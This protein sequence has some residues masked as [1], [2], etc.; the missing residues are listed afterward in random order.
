VKLVVFVFLAG[1]IAG[2]ALGRFDH[3]T[4]ERRRALAAGALV[5]LID[6]QPNH[7]AL[8][9]QFKATYAEAVLKAL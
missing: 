8:W 9:Q 7:A 4:D 5:R 6:A 2:I 3:N 1:L